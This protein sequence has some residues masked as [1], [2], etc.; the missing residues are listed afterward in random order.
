MRHHN[1]IFTD[2]NELEMIQEIV[3]WFF[4][5]FFNKFI[6]FTFLRFFP[7]L[8]Y[9]FHLFSIRFRIIVRIIIFFEFKGE[10]VVLKIYRL[11]D[12]TITRNNR[13]QYSDVTYRK[14]WNR[15]GRHEKRITLID[16][17]RPH[18]PEVLHPLDVWSCP[19]D[20]R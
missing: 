13:Y 8:F 9:Y 10:I 20:C 14:T 19:L 12:R 3:F 4:F 15:I 6:N 2:V 17:F 7:L 11:R 5:F 16:Y 1:K 18:E